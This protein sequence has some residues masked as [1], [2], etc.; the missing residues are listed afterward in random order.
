MRLWTKSKYIAMLAF[1]VSSY[2]NNNAIISLFMLEL[3]LMCEHYVVNVY[4]VDMIIVLCPLVFPF[5]YFF[6]N[7]SL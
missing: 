7:D 4:I 3:K 6:L 5:L 2:D 1:E